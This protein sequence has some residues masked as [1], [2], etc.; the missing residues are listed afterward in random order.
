MAN[1]V[2][3][4]KKYKA[5]FAPKKTPQIVEVPPL[6]YLMIDGAGAPESAAFAE[7]IAALYPAAYAL[8][9]HHKTAGKGDFVVAP[10]EALW[11]ADDWTVFMANQRQDWR[12]TAMI[13]Q[14]DFVSPDDLAVVL[15][16]LEKKKKR[17][18]LHDRMRLETLEEGKAV[19][20]MHHG[21]YSA[22]GPVI[23]N[24]HAFAEGE[25]YPLT[26]KHHEI[27]LSDMRR[28]APEKLKTVLRQP[29]A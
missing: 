12:W 18:P 20:V 1:K 4:K 5:L 17:V 25:G 26:G 16:A 22:E 23:A 2:D 8:K 14:P 3:L 15:K 29:V 9:F 7:A 27:Y 11:W 13:M 6:R 21:P 28:T 24:M 19:Q 10:L